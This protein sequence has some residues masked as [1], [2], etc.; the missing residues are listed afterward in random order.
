MRPIILCYFKNISYCKITSITAQPKTAGKKV[1]VQEKHKRK[2]RW[3]RAYTS[4]TEIQEGTL[5]SSGGTDRHSQHATT[6]GELQTTY[7]SALS[8]HKLNR[9]SFWVKGFCRTSLGRL[10]EPRTLSPREWG[11]GSSTDE[12]GSRSSIRRGKVKTD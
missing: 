12:E 9:V 4:H 5:D 10:C 1:A 8:S 6:F 7:I 11:R 3:R 2:P